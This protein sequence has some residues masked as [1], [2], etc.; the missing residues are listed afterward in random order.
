M[1]R[2][3]LLADRMN[4]LPPD[5]PDTT[6]ATLLLSKHIEQLWR[7]GFHRLA[8][9]SRGV[10]AQCRD[11]LTGTC[12]DGDREFAAWI[13]ETTPINELLGILLDPSSE[14]VI[15]ELALAWADRQMP[16]VAWI[17]QAYGSEIVRHR[18][19]LSHAATGSGALGRNRE[20]RSHRAPSSR[21]W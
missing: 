7:I 12:L 18:Q 20:R 6:P 1:V 9:R 19:S 15:A 5:P 13:N 10:A 16:V 14:E 11:L 21:G 2:W 3:S 17:E 8:A 4:L